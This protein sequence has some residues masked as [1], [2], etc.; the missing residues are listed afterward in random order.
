MSIRTIPSRAFNQNVTEAKKSALQQP[1]FI[2]DRG[3]ITHVL[4]NINDYKKITQKTD[5]IIDLLAMPE[6]DTDIPEFDAPRINDTLFKP[7]D[8]S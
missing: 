1:V 3:N 5:S 2:T 8:F 4:L 7:A 6:A